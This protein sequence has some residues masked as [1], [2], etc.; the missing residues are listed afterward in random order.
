MLESWI[1]EVTL[2]TSLVVEGVAALIVAYAVAEAIVRLLMSFRRHSGDQP[3]HVA[4]DAK[5]DIRLRLGRWLAL[6]LELLLGADIL[7]TAVAPSWSEIGQ[8]AAIAAIRT[9]LN[10]FLQR[11]IEAAQGRR[12][13]Q[14]ST[15]DQGK[16]DGTG[17][18]ALR[19]RS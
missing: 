13:R 12:A 10:F 18:E 3:S 14:S 2:A 4:H 6:S 11:E 17:T 15:G 5:E 8:L 19:A 16:N 9:A 1:R 7:R